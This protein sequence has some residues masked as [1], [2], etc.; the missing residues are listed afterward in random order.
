MYVLIIIF[1]KNWKMNI[2]E[3]AFLYGG[4][5]VYPTQ[6]AIWMIVKMIYY[7][8]VIV[9][10]MSVCSVVPSKKIRGLTFIG[11]RTMQIYFWHIIIRSVVSATGIPDHICVNPA[12]HI[13]W[14]LISIAV[15]GILSLGIFS[16]PTGWIISSVKKR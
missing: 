11:R 15:T 1:G 16:F 3:A 13:V 7:V 8:T 9:I 2:S 4:T 12:G 6:S 14:T 5:G 10:S